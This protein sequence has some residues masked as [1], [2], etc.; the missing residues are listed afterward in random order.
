[1]FTHG[2][3]LQV[4]QQDG[5]DWVL[6]RDLIWKDGIDDVHVPAGF[7]TDFASI[8]R[9]AWFIW[10]KS[11]SHNAAAVVH[12]FQCRVGRIP[13]IVAAQQFERMLKWLDENG[14]PNPWIKRKAFYAAVRF[15]GPKW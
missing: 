3:P 13:P 7:L 4:V 6:T 15:F 12:D 9:V 1:M 10:N 8:P 2:F 11:G 5:G 14:W